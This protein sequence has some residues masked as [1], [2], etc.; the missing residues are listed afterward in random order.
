MHDS[1]KVHLQRVHLVG[2]MNNYNFVYF[3]ASFHTGDEK[4]LNFSKKALSNIL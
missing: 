2:V 3:N 1:H 4:I